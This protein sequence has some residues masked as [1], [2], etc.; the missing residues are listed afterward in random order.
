MKIKKIL[1]K[2]FPS[3][4]NYYT[5]TREYLYLCKKRKRLKKELKYIDTIPSK[6]RDALKMLKNKKKL[7]CVFLALFE[8]TWKC[9]KV[10]QLMNNNKRFEPIILVCPIVNYGEKN[11]ISRLNSAYSFFSSLGYK[12]IKSYDEKTN[13]Y[14]HIEDLA[15]DILFY[16]NPYEGLI[17]DRY[18]ITNYSQYLTLYVPYGF[19]PSND[20]NLTTNL[21]LHNVVWRFY[22]ESRAHLT[23]IQ[24]NRV[25]GRNAV[26]TGYPGIESLIDPSYIIK[27]NNWKITNKRVKRIIWAPHHTIA[28]IGNVNY[29]CFIQYADFM[30]EMAEKYQDQVEFVFKPHP[31]LKNK[32]EEIW[33]KKKVDNYYKQWSVKPNCNIVN[34]NYIDLF[35]SSDAMIHDCG[36]F[37][38]E[39]LYVN[40]PVM[41]TLNDVPLENLYN[42]FAQ[43]CLEQY[44]FA[45][46]KQDIELFILNII[47]EIDPLKEQRTKFINEVLIPKGSPSQNIIDDILD[48]IDNQI[49][50]RN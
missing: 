50:F 19:N 28:P 48:S 4:S 23:Y 39:Y 17:D 7:R 10:Y 45:R 36:S 35:L 6:Q 41:R 27:E 37:L 22:C 49:L 31:L 44:Y 11:M 16:T 1:K 18:Y 25:N 32:L 15:P 20:Y 3:M 21:L 30:L 47:N 2:T 42:P 13:T 34:G 12:V 38:I 40:K 26:V 43:K 8:D 14:I 29:S 24:G 33:S 9:D 46:T 5:H